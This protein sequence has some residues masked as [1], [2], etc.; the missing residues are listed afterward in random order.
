MMV[1]GINGGESMMSLLHKFFCALFGK[2]SQRQAGISTASIDA[3][4]NRGGHFLLTEV[5]NQKSINK[6][7]IIT[8][9]PR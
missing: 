6:V 1:G 3:W 4:I 8:Q 2:V 5:V 9:L 7:G